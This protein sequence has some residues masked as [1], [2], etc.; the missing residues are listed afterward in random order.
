MKVFKN[1]YGLKIHQAITKY[2]SRKEQKERTVNTDG[3]TWN[4]SQEANQCAED[5]LHNAATQ[6]NIENKNQQRTYTFS[7]PHDC[8]IQLPVT[9]NRRWENYDED[10]DNILANTLTG[11]VQRTILSL[12]TIVYAEGQDIFGVSSTKTRKKHSG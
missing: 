12:S 3:T 9:D 11:D 4:H 7:R 10:L 2:R 6:I 1:L 8:R 5:L